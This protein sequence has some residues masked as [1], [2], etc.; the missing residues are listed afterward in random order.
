MCNKIHRK[1]EIHEQLNNNRNDKSYSTDDSDQIL[2]SKDKNFKSKNHNNRHRS[3]SRK[4]SKFVLFSN[5]I[6][7]DFIFLR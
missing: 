7:V 6:K 2:I 1:N 5:Y 4:H 3:K